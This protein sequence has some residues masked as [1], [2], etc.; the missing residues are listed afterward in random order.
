[1]HQPDYVAFLPLL[2]VGGLL[3][4]L[5]VV[6]ILLLRNRSAKQPSAGMSADDRERLY[7]SRKDKLHEERSRILDMVAGGKVSAEEGDQLL[8]TIERETSTMAC[9][10]CGEDIRVEAAKCKHC[11]RY[12]VGGTS[13]PRRLYRTDGPIA[14]VCGGLAEYAE[15]DPALV[16]ILTVLIALFSSGVPV[17]LSYII[18]AIII[19]PK[20]E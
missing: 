9:P 12:L 17:L 2:L 3:L 20:G 16:R 8:N 19:P 11:N 5:V 10:F 13:E 15:M 4:L 1:M 6:V 18:A 14:G 7:R